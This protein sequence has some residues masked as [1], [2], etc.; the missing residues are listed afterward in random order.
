MKKIAVILICLFCGL[1]SVNTYADFS[2]TW[3][4]D[5]KLSI[6]AGENETG[7]VVTNRLNE[8]LYINQGTGIFKTNIKN[9]SEIKINLG[10][11]ITD[12]VYGDILSKKTGIIYVSP[13]GNDSND[14]TLYSPLQTVSAALAAADTGDTVKLLGEVAADSVDCGKNVVISGGILDIS[15]SGTFR[16]S[17]N[18]ELADITVK[19]SAQERIIFCGNIKIGKNVNFENDADIECDG[20]VRIEDGNYNSITVNDSETY[21]LQGVYI[22]S[23][24]YTDESSMLVFEGCDF[25]KKLNES[26]GK[27]FILGKNGTV[28]KEEKKIKISP[29]DERAYSIN[30]AKYQTDSFIPDENGVYRIDFLYNVKLH[31]VGVSQNNGTY[32][33]TVA[34][35][36]NNLNNEVPIVR[37]I[38]AVYGKDGIL[39]EM[40]SGEYD[41]KNITMQYSS[42][43]MTA[44]DTIKI[45]VWDSFKRLVP[46]AGVSLGT[47]SELT[48]AKKEFYVSPSGND[49]NP[50]TITSPF[51]TL[52]KAQSAARLAGEGT[53]VYFRK[54]EYY[55]PAKC[56]FTSS[57]S[58]ITYKAYNGEKAVFTT[59]KSMKG[60][61]F[62]E[63][64][65]DIKNRIKNENAKEKVLR[66]KLDANGFGSIPEIE[67]RSY[68]NKAINP[69]LFSDSK[70]MTPARY[71]DSGYIN[72]TSVTDSGVGV[73]RTGD[74]SER[75]PIAFSSEG[76]AGKINEWNVSDGFYIF[77]YLG[78][79]WSDAFYRCAFTEDK[80]VVT[81]NANSGY[82]IR[83]DDRFY[84]GNILEE[85]NS[86]GEW[87][88]DKENNYI[89]I[90]PFADFNENSKI[91]YNVR[92]T[93]L[94]SFINIKGAE[95]LVF[96]GIVFDGISANDYCINISDYCDGVVIKN[97]E[98][99]N[100][101]CKA[102][103][104]KKSENCR[105][106]GNYAHDL[107]RGVFV[108]DG[109]DA[110]TLTPGQNEA[111]NN[112][113]ER[114]AQEN[115]TYEPA[116]ALYGV[117]NKA[118]HNEISDS[119][120]MAIGFYG[121]KCIIEYNEIYNVCNDTLDS[122][123]IYAGLTFTAPGNIMRFNYIHDIENKVKEMTGTATTVVG[124]YFDERLSGEYVYSNVFENIDR[125]CF[126]GSGRY[127]T[128]ERNV[129]INCPQSVYVSRYWTF[130]E[131]LLDGL[132]IYENNALWKKEFPWIA[133]T[134]EDEP[135]EPKYNRVNDN[136][137][138]NSAMPQIPEKYSYLL[139][140]TGNVIFDSTDI[141]ADYDNKDF[142]ILAKSDIYKEI[143]GF[144]VIPFGEIGLTG[145]KGETR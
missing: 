67:D 82:A 111:V 13:K 136:V 106:E 57:D 79:D 131:S 117:G 132:K 104:I 70:R 38:A 126:I 110:K 50:G 48:A 36:N 29:E 25:S 119:A 33:L 69:I 55:F 86:E 34:A 133:E 92:N 6:D 80:K 96:D 139:D 107:S 102:A 68:S 7:V 12:T 37:I 120:H 11:G 142:S 118:S 40:T 140:P 51:A 109:G 20:K 9:Q 22:K 63:V 56:N 26:V 134:A 62:E 135:K 21:L 114:F 76:L 85:L 138:Y 141:F 53:T 75:R 87:Y 145:E 54:G 1:V 73:N 52:K 49:A 64:P 46:L 124:I 27:I 2:A 129:M 93:L 130:N 65:Q 100:L 121:Q 143:P 5:G 94:D 24:I 108:I 113:I 83:K 99:T 81:A 3:D 31:S 89:Y 28:K 30:G 23:G 127:N 137:L 98:F 15:Q 42:A 84:C 43:K 44:N 8:I 59:V 41:S 122:G 105:I 103:L 60:S 123:A 72:V 39:K 32:K 74:V 97:C 19:N 88:F 144:G 4:D 101:V 115:T 17:G 128:I 35:V 90:Y 18:I 47:V 91:K 14:G 45:F 95:N 71:P 125:A 61:M 66:I 58:G 78:A 112:K 10:D 77:G 116:I 16:F